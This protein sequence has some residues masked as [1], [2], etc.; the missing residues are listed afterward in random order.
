MLPKTLEPV[1]ASGLN[2]PIMTGS[3]TSAALGRAAD[4]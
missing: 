2:S 1:E 3:L 4:R